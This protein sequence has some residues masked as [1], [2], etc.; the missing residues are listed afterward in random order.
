MSL[1]NKMLIFGLCSTSD[2]QLRD[3]SDECWP[4][5]KKKKKG[6]WG[7][8]KIKCSFLDYVQ[9]LMI[10]QVI[11]VT[12]VNQNAKKKMKKGPLCHWKIRCSFLDYVQLLMIG[13]V[14]WASNVNWKAKEMKEGPLCHWK[15]KCSVL[16]YIQLLMISRAIQATKVNWN[17]EKGPLSDWKMK[18]SLLYYIQLLMIGQ[19]IQVTKVYWNVKKWHVVSVRVFCS[20]SLGL[21][22]AFPLLLDGKVEI[23][24]TEKFRFFRFTFNKF[25]PK[26]NSVQSLLH[27]LAMQL[28]CDGQWTNWFTLH[29]YNL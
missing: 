9:L 7:H 27:L 29:F 1:K 3:L 25:Q 20:F 12:N 4:K 16:D 2:D 28:I 5:C 14:I 11:W 22:Y 10:S 23:R 21:L 19:A 26:D 24:V 17:V 6:P 15:I 18:Y 8:E 13:R